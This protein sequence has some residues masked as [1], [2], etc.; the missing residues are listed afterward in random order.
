MQIL[1]EALQSRQQF[2]CNYITMLH[3]IVYPFVYKFQTGF[4][5]ILTM[6]NYNTLSFLRGLSQ[7]VDDQLNIQSDHSPKAL[8]TA[9]PSK[10]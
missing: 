2:F 5:S 4:S 8:C 9:N 3:V 7:T 10:M 6:D 1:N